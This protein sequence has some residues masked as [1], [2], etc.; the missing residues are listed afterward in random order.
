VTDPGH[1]H[2]WD[3]PNAE[4][5]GNQAGF[6][7]GNNKVGTRSGNTQSASAGLVINSN[8]TGLTINNGLTNITQTL[9]CTTAIS[10]NNSPVAAP[11]PD[12]TRPVNFALLPILKYKESP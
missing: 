10:V 5:V 9:I 2:R 4:V 6:Y 11:V 8:T 7:D 12:E 3:V 1:S